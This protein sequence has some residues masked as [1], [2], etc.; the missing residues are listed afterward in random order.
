MDIRVLRYFLAVA[1]EGSMTG[2]AN[3]MHVSQPTLSKQLKDLEEELGKKLFTRYSHSVSLTDEGMLL[4][5]RAE[6][7]IDM[8]DKTVDEFNTLGDII[9][10]DIHIGSAETDSLTHI[11][12]VAKQLQIRYPDICYHIT[13]GNSYDVMAVFYTTLTLPKKR[14][15]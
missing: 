5:K 6:D 2:A 4:R 8:F 9:A 10:G 7:I 13:S 15:V 3:F 14:I 12:Q 1:R 11:A